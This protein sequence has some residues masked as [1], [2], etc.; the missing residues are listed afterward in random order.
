MKRYYLVLSFCTLIPHLAVAQGEP[1][2][3]IAEKVSYSPAIPKGLWAF[4][5]RGGTSRFWGES[6]IEYHGKKVWVH[7]YDVQKTQFRKGAT[8]EVRRE[9][10]AEEG[11]QD[12][13]LDLFVFSTPRRLKRI[14]STRF[15]YKRFGGYKRGGDFETVGVQ[16]LW[17]DPKNQKMP[18]VQVALQDPNGLY[19]T[20]TNYAIC[21]FNE[22]VGKKAVVELRFGKGA[23]NGG[24]WVNWDS[25]FAVMNNGL[26]GISY[27]QARIETRVTYY[28]WESNQFKAF[29]RMLLD[30]DEPDKSVEVPFDTP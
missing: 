21:V 27:T 13:G 18:I 5:H 16:T 2:P 7:V 23:S 15:T 3:V 8:A 9:A 22:A 19:G 17:L 24:A 20:F 12:S 14:S 6:N 30:R 25:G 26:T 11:D 28:R 10:T 29:R 1:T 4:L